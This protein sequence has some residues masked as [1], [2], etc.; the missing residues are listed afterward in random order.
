MDELHQLKEE[1]KLIKERNAR[2]EADKAWETSA[3]RKVLIVI[4]TYI[5]VALFFV[6]AGL[7]NPLI[8]A[9]VPS[10]AFVLSTLT[11]P[12]FKGLWLKEYFLDKKKTRG[13]TNG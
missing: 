2:V 4:L 10:L 8:N 11:I 1:I 3:A 7:P 9:I 12:L 6:V 13:Q 5:V